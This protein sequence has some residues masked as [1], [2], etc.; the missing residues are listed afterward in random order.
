MILVSA[1]MLILALLVPSNFI[2]DFTAFLTT[3]LYDSMDS[4]QLDR[5]LS[6]S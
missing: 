1:T 3:V 4:G 6:G 2:P 5:L